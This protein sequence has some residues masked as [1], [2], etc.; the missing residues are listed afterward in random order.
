[1]TQPRRISV[2]GATGSGKT[3]LGKMIAARGGLR[4]IDLDELHWLP[5]WKEDSN[6]N[7]RAK[8][9]AATAGDGWVVTGNYSVTRDVYDDRLDTVVWLD[10]AFPRVFWQLLCRSFRRARDGEPICNGNVE[11][12]GKL[13]SR[14]S[15]I[16]WLFTSW[17]RRRQSG[18][19]AFAPGNRREGLHYVRL[20][21]PQEARRW[22]D[23]TFGE[24]DAGK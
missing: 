24:E 11:T 8:V 12:W 5:G 7:F 14:D 17:R 3:T 20:K 4:H 15:I 13:F 18:R 22:V 9:A 10:Y 23:Q 2:T 16:V 21:T 19:D 6:E 1:M